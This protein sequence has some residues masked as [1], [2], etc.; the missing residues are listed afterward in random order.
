MGHVMLILSELSVVFAAILF[1]YLC[2]KIPTKEQQLLHLISTCTFI[3]ALGGAITANAPTSRV[4]EAGLYIS[5][6]GGAYIGFCYL[7]ILTLLTHLKIPKIIEAVIC[8]INLCFV[9]CAITNPTHHHM[10][11]GLA[12]AIIKGESA[13]RYVT[14]GPAFYAYAIWHIILL[15]MA[16]HIIRICRLKR[17]VIYKSMRK[18]IYAYVFACMTAFGFFVYSNSIDARYDYSG[19]VFCIC[20]YFL[21]IMTYRFRTLPLNQG[22]RDAVLDT[23][24]DIIVGTD[25]LNRYIFSNKHAKDVFNAS[26][27][28]AY[29]ITLNNIT[30]EIDEFLSLKDGDSYSK[31]TNTYICSIVDIMSGSKSVGKVHWLKNITM[32]Q[33][34]VAE[35]IRL[36]E[37]AEAA[38]IAKSQFLA[39][40]SH[41]I[42]TP[43]NAILGLNELTL[44]ESKE[45]NILDYAENIKISGESLLT[46]INDILDY[47]KLE[48]GKIELAHSDYDLAIMI[49]DLVVSTQTR[50]GEKDIKFNTIIDPTLPRILKG[51]AVRVKQ[52]IMN[53][54]SN[55]AKYTEKGHIDLKISYEPKD[56][57]S[58]L[59]KIAVSDTG[60]GI[61]EEDI[62]KL[63]ERFEQLK[64]K[65]YGALEGT[66]LGMSITKKILD[67]MGGAVL[68]DS[69]VGEGSSFYML[70]PQEVSSY[71]NIGE[72][73][74]LNIKNAFAKT[75][76]RERFTAPDAKVLVV[77]D[78]K[79]NRRLAIELLKET[80]MQFFEAESGPKMLE[81]IKEEHFD[82]ILLDHRMPEMSG[83]DALEAMHKDDTHK[84]VGVPVVAMTADAGA[85][86]K[87]YFLASGFTDYISKPLNPLLYEELV[88]KILP[89][90]LVNRQ[91]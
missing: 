45:E 54:L 9:M 31:G 50:I 58:I 8:F 24:D 83:V 10:Y 89:K 69:K 11:K 30:P 85:N 84:C 6:F 44:R 57:S 63:F 17:P 78:N 90:E 51:D 72:F 74:N 49:K 5:Y 28:F 22:T 79:I 25:H 2:F 65:D 37:A 1:L 4:A 75:V 70:I 59:L 32:E 16:F 46:I 35:T 71:E 20:S 21:L 12:Y 88:L 42:R 82:L 52:V 56:D 3:L 53:V 86:A 19:I 61:K 77:D 33:S 73:G 68:V 13:T 38:N 76:K 64:R 60:I 39:H 14:F 23:I 47:S 62:P 15:I 55:A 48:S 80:N 67:I 18:I 66:G 40:M 29:G 41:E 91:S 7:L 27:F 34:F 81:M 36:K 87:E 43:I 26:D